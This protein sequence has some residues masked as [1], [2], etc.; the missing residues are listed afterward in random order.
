Q[1]QPPVARPGHSI[2]TAGARRSVRAGSSKSTRDE[3]REKSPLRL[4]SNREPAWGLS[5][6]SRRNPSVIIEG[7]EGNAAI[8]RNLTF[9]SPMQ[10]SVHLVR[11]VIHLLL[12]NQ[13]P[14]RRGRVR[15]D[16]QAL[17]MFLPV[18]DEKDAVT[19]RRDLL[20]AGPEA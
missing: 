1:S 14:H 5:P 18:H 12:R 19:A 9:T 8:R 11:I 2:Q 16:A 20:G 7:R 4:A 15:I 17:S 10:F 6:H 13:I 3:N